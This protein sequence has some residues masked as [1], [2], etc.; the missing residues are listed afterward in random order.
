MKKTTDNYW[1]KKQWCERLQTFT[2]FIFVALEIAALVF[3]YVNGYITGFKGI[4]H[5][6]FFVLLSIPCLGMLRNVS[7]MIIW[8][9]LFLISRIALANHMFNKD[10]PKIILA[11]VIMSAVTFVSKLIDWT[12]E[13]IFEKFIY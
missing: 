5:S 8:H 7:D 1:K 9:F 4:L 12:I 13:K 6:L 10:I 3:F 11:V 2:V